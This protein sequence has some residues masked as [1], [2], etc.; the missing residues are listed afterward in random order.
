[1]Y[2]RVRKK[3]NKRNGAEM[4]YTPELVACGT[5]PTASDVVPLV[6]SNGPCA[7]LGS[8][9]GF[10]K[11]AALLREALGSDRFLNLE[12]ELEG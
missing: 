11:Q 3:T 5:G 6:S 1:M 2:K 9:A 12:G 7:R 8:P 4:Q 10:P